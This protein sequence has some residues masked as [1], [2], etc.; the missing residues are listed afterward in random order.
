ML[1]V[2][3]VHD[4]SYYYCLQIADNIRKPLPG[5][6]TAY[7][8]PALNIL[9]SRLTELVISLDSSLVRKSNKKEK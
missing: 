6:I 1:R 9:R 4:V 3:W 8:F 5:L 7:L 2:V